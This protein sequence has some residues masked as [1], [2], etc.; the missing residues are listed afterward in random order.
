MPLQGE[1]KHWNRAAYALSTLI[2]HTCGQFDVR[3][4]CFDEVPSC[5]GS[6]WI[7]QTFGENALVRNAQIEEQ[8]N[9]LYEP[10]KFLGLF[11]SCVFAKL[12][13]TSMKEFSKY[14]R[15]ITIDSDMEFI[16][17]LSP[18]FS[19]PVDT[20]FAA[21]REDVTPTWGSRAIPYHWWPEDAPRPKKG[22]DAPYYNAGFLI[23]DSHT[24]PANY[25]HI[26]DTELDSLADKK[27]MYLE[28]DFINEHFDIQ[29]L[30]SEYIVLKGGEHAD[31]TEIASAK[32]IH[33]NGGV[34]VKVGLDVKV[35]K[36]IK[37]APVDTTVIHWGKYFDRIYCLHY[38]GH[39]GERICS[40]NKELARVGILDS[41]I[42]EYRYT[43]KDP[44][45]RHVEHAVKRLATK[46]EVNRAYVNLMLAT[47]RIYR[48]ALALGMKRILVLEDDIRFLKDLTKVKDM[49]ENMPT[50][51]G[52]VQF[53]KGL[54]TDS[55][56]DKVEFFDWVKNRL[57]PGT[58]GQFFDPHAEWFGS[59]ACVAF[60]PQGMKD[61]LAALELD[62]GATDSSYRKCKSYVAAVKNLG[63]QCMYPSSALQVLFGRDVHH[64]G[65]THMG[66]DLDE[67]NLPNYDVCDVP[68]EAP[69]NLGTEH[70]LK[71]HVYAITKNETKFV[72][73]WVDSMKEA[74]GIHVLDTGSTD[75]T[76]E[77]LRA[78]GVHVE[79]KTYNPWRF[80]VPRNDSMALCPDDA[81]ILVCTD[82]D[83][84]LRPGWRDK[85]E[86]Q[87]LAAL[88][89]GKHP[90][91]ARYDYIWSFQPDGSPA[92]Q[93][94]YEKIHVPHEYEWRYAVHEL[95]FR[96]DNG[97]TEYL[98]TSGIM[99]EHHPDHTKSRGSYLGLLELSVK[100]DPS[101]DRNTHYLGRELTFYGRW[102]D[103]IEVLEKH[104]SMNGWY[105]ERAMSYAY[106]GRCYWNLGD[107]EAADA[108]W[109]KAS[110][111]ATDHREAAF[112][113]AD[114]HYKSGEWDKVIEFCTILF[115]VKNQAGDYMTDQTAW[116]WKPYD[117]LGIALWYSGDR[118]GARQV[119]AL[120]CDKFPDNSHLR[121]N[122]RRCAGEWNWI[123]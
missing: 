100:E 88:E 91:V 42:F 115:K 55:P 49:L 98:E 90:K 69:I 94:R 121:D 118:D 46:D 41:G 63:V 53:D 3:I 110:E 8:C 43:T 66:L 81:D 71:I 77:K 35:D 73:R 61:M 72:D 2:R 80:D 57:I 108:A 44:F 89:S 76:V 95:L 106:I 82:L 97:H 16:G 56:W 37:E 12:Y 101:N 109:R 45:E 7:L 48:E 120:A 111:I 36:F 34:E 119:F 87:W 19:I 113:A 62:F 114:S 15:L 26:R 27:F 6:D 31:E 123:A 38:T 50:S 17:D 65:Y 84:V 64:D 112:E 33:Y 1:A 28:Q 70:K 30:P 54:A 11:A 39:L 23:I 105:A 29:E 32:I 102:K 47:A 9:K 58:N 75:D 92:R 59:S 116:G 96:K 10:H 107:K 99:L 83:E 18:L 14:N 103:A 22:D 79:V 104:V 93:F 51:A 74:D 21:F 52:I 60:T 78:R 4:M 117:I 20:G 68:T 40:H 122:L 67:Y 13:Y 24:L 25:P 85:L 5:K 86:S